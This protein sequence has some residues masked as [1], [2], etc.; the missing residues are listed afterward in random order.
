MVSKRFVLGLFSIYERDL[1]LIYTHFRE[2]LAPAVTT[3][4]SSINIA[5]NPYGSCHP[6]HCCSTQP[7]AFW[8]VVCVGGP[9]EKFV[10]TVRAE[11]RGLAELGVLNREFIRAQVLDSRWYWLVIVTKRLL[12]D[13]QISRIDGFVHAQHA[14]MLQVCFSH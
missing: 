7:A 11:T 6:T 12:I 10:Q 3:S 14:F 13:F 4:L 2:L 8:R 9:I 1:K 5:T